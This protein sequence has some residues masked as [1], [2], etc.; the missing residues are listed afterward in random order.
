MWSGQIPAK[1]AAVAGWEWEK[2]GV[3]VP[4]LDSRVRSRERSCRRARSAELRFCGRG[5]S[6]L[7]TKG[8]RAGQQATRG[9][10]VSPRE[11]SRVV[12]CGGEAGGGDDRVGRNGGLGAR[13]GEGDRATY[14]RERGS[15]TPSPRRKGSPAL[16]PQYGGRGTAHQQGTPWK[17]AVHRG[18]VRPVRRGHEP[19]HGAREGETSGGLGMRGGLGKARARPREAWARMPR[20]V[21]RARGCAGVLE[22]GWRR[23]RGGSAQR[24]GLVTFDRVFLKIFE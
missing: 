5:G 6:V 11:G 9:V 18:L 20:A 22:R 7:A 16:R 10:L 12:C 15:A 17:P 23:G 24:V 19:A 8:A 21:Q 2:G 14:S 13:D 1:P 4:G 3:E